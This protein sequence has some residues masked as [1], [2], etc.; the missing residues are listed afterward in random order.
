[1][2][3]LCD[4]IIKHIDLDERLTEM[5]NKLDRVRDHQ[6]RETSFF[7]FVFIII[8]TMVTNL[9][10]Q[11]VYNNYITNYGR[12]THYNTDSLVMMLVFSVIG[13]CVVILYALDV[14]NISKII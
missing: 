4:N 12:G 5:E 6:E 3:I 13:V 11:L 1:M 2:N 7:A 8:I 14:K 10:A 9:W